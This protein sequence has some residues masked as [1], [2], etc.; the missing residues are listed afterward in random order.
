V[1]QHA[2]LLETQLI[3]EVA[4]VV[5]QVVKQ[6]PQTEGVSKAALEREVQAQVDLILWMHTQ[7]GLLID[8][9]MS[10][11]LCQIIR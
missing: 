2:Y 8:L 7:D 6:V 9:S 11:E 4:G 3:H 1:K 5:V 10:H